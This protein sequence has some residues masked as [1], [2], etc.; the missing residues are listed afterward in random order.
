[1]CPKLRANVLNRKEY[2]THLE[3]L[4]CN[5]IDQGLLPVNR[6]WMFPSSL[7]TVG[8]STALNEVLYLP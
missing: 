4:A 7:S 3:F 8:H 1:M 6:N 5:F 2:G